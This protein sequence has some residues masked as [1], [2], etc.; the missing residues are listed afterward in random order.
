MT[1]NLT[2][3]TTD[4][5][6][7]V[8]AILR[9]AEASDGTPEQTEQALQAALVHAPDSLPLRIATYAFY[10]YANRL[11]EAIPHAEACLTMAATALGVPVD[12]REVSPESA[13]FGGFDRPQRV[14]LK[15]LV[16]L[17][18]CHARLGQRDDGV[19]ILRKAA[20][21]DPQ[22]QLGAALMAD[23]IARGIVDDDD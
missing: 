20:S 14:Y 17:G 4:M 23:V 10:F 18:F 3:F 15:S 21:L 5:P 6:E 13:E 11:E 2:A 12:W 19:A 7:D 1:I 9:N 16:A 8:L 22:D